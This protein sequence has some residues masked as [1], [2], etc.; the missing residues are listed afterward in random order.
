MFVYKSGTH[1]FNN[2]EHARIKK[3]LS[4]GVQIW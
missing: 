2:D 3:V 4:E 1:I